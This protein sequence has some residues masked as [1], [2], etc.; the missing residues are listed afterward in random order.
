[1]VL[2]R[3]NEN[4]GFE[5]SRFSNDFLKSQILLTAA[6][7]NSE[8][9]RTIS[10]Y[11]WMDMKLTKDIHARIIG[12]LWDSIVSKST[13]EYWIQVFKRRRDSLKDDHYPVTLTVETTSAPFKN[14]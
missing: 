12:C 1:M 5:E 3:R 11:E 8:R 2:M 14:C 13:V 6:N 9:I 7:S 4:G 10:Y